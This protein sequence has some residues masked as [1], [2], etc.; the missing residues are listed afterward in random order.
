MKRQLRLHFQG[1]SCLLFLKNSQHKIIL[2]PKR[3]IWGWYIL[4]SFSIQDA[5]RLAESAQWELAGHKGYRNGGQGSKGQWWMA[6]PRPVGVTAKA[7]EEIRYRHGPNQRGQVVS[8]PAANAS[9]RSSSRM[10]KRRES[11]RP[12]LRPV[13]LSTQQSLSMGTCI[14]LTPLH[15]LSQR[16][17][18]VTPHLRAEH[19]QSRGAGRHQAI[20]SH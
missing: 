4:C 14:S 7:S 8:H 20:S 1:F 2:K 9:K 17:P 16:G 11:Q 6:G 19:L 3:H 18:G 5:Q 10:R 13:L 12:V 15:T